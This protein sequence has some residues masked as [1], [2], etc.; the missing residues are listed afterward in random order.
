MKNFRLILSL[1]LTL[2][3]FSGFTFGNSD[4]ERR[5]E[6]LNDSK[7]ALELLYQEE[8]TAKEEIQSAYGYATF[9]NYGMSIMISFE[10]GT[11]LAHNNKTKQVTYMN[12]GSSGLGMG[13]GAKEFM[14][15]FVFENKKVFDKFLKDGWEANAQIDMAIRSDEDG[16][17]INEAHTIEN[18][19]KLYKLTKNG[20]AMQMNIHGSKYWKCRDLN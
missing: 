20:L 15:V 9:K 5:A 14:A 13:F 10:G 12:M 4:E 7:E 1:F 8:P 2:F 19:V 17:S 11:G 18:G 3:L 6:R 16:E